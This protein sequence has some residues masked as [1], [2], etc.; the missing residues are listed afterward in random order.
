MNAV[1]KELNSSIHAIILNNRIKA[2]QQDWMRKGII[3]KKKLT[4]R[5][6]FAYTFVLSF[7]DRLH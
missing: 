3:D 1:N 5:N 7:F 4:D 6:R 2:C